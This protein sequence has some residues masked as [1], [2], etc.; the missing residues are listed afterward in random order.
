MVCGLDSRSWRWLELGLLLLLHGG[1]LDSR[2]AAADEIGGLGLILLLRS[3][4]GGY[5]SGGGLNDEKNAVFT[6]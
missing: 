1:D 6:V 4:G 3:G 2:A 5:G